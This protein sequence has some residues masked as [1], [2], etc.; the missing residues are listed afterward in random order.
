MEWWVYIE[1][2]ERGS[3]P[4]AEGSLSCL[5]SLT[6]HQCSRC[7]RFYPETNSW[8]SIGGKPERNIKMILELRD[9]NQEL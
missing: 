1:T 2:L 4:R 6:L 3:W 8:K 5:P 9:K 7:I